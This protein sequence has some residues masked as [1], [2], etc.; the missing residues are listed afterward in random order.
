MISG[1]PNQYAPFPSLPFPCVRTRSK[2][3]TLSELLIGVALIGVIATFALPKILSIYNEKIELQKYRSS[4]S[5]LSQL[6]F[7]AW[8]NDAVHNKSETIDYFKSHLNYQVFQTSWPNDI[9]ILHDGTNI[10]VEGYYAP[11]NKASFRVKAR[12]TPWGTAQQ[13]V[14]WLYLQCNFDR[15]NNT[16]NASAQPVKP[17][18]VSSGYDNHPAYSGSK[19]IWEKMYPPG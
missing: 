3:F 5:V 9:F 14:D 15:N 1:D 16:I 10:Q 18:M 6:C 2:A 8:Q 7:D 12:N 19:A 13:G 4:A 17:G 11:Q